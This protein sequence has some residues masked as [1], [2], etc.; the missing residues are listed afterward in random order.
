M[1][2]DRHYC[3]VYQGEQIRRDT[4]NDA[5]PNTVFDLLKK[6]IPQCP[7]LKFVVL[8]QLGTGLKT[9][10]QKL[11]FQKD[12]IQMD[13]IINDSDDPMSPKNNQSTLANSPWQVEQWE[14]KMLETVIKIAQKW[15]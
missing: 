14:P 6:T 7:N 8:E 11:A 5:V 12:F 10:A 4:H 1:E 15:K 3:L 13:T 9:E 2:W